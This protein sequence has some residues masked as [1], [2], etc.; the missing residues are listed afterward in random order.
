[1]RDGLLDGVLLGSIETAGTSTESR[2]VG[3]GLLDVL[4]E[5]IRSP[6]LYVLPLVSDEGL[7]LAG[8]G[9]GRFRR[10]GTF[11]PEDEQWYLQGEV[12]N[13]VLV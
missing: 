10:V 5:D 1:M 11:R 9:S 12:Q 8:A 2:I 3:L 13:L 6:R 7:L 4:G